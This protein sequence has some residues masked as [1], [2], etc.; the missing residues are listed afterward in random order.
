ML[1][2]YPFVFRQNLNRC[3]QLCRKRL[4][5]WT[6]PLPHARI[7]NRE[8]T[9]DYMESLGKSAGSSSG[10]EATWPWSPTVDL[11]RR[12]AANDRT[13]F[14]FLCFHTNRV[15]DTRSYIQCLVFCCSS[16]ASSPAVVPYMVIIVGVSFPLDVGMPISRQKYVPLLI[17]DAEHTSTYLFHLA[18][19]SWVAYSLQLKRKREGN[20]PG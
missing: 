1:P 9:L 2:L 7:T 5:S 16:P 18:P 4:S 15:L 17:T 10:R 3:P 6:G 12:G 11:R 13:A 8:G 20:R 14:Y 19:F